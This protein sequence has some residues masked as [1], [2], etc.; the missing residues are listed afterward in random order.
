MQCKTVC[1]RTAEQSV[2][3]EFLAIKPLIKLLICAKQFTA[4]LQTYN[5]YMI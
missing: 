5:V 1:K 4:L 2:S 3:K